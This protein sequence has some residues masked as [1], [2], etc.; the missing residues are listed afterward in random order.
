MKK[1]MFVVSLAFVVSCS[2][3]SDVALFD[4]PDP[5]VDLI[6]EIWDPDIF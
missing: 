1:L 3:V 6:I 2:H 5:C 4:E